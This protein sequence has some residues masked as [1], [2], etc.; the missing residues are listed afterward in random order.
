MRKVWSKNTNRIERCLIWSANK[1]CVGLGHLSLSMA[2]SVAISIII[3]LQVIF[4]LFHHAFSPILKSLIF[5]CIS[6]HLPELGCSIALWRKWNSATPTSLFYRK[7]SKLTNMP[8]PGSVGGFNFFCSAID[9]GVPQIRDLH[10]LCLVLS[11]VQVKN[12][13]IPKN[14]FLCRTGPCP[15]HQIKK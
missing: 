3:C 10:T 12:V 9:F 13:K 6:S 11:I 1:N 15:G 7:K 14:P 2:Q 8:W 5:W 4:L